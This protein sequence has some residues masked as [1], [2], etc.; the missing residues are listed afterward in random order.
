MEDRVGIESLGRGST[1]DQ[2]PLALGFLRCDGPFGGLPFQA[3]LLDA[4]VVRSVDLELDL[5]GFQEDFGPGHSLGV[6]RRLFV[7]SDDDVQ[8]KWA[9]GREPKAID[10]LDFVGRGC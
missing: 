3:D 6:D 10:P 2:D 7:G 9:F 8:R 4:K 1:G 5:F